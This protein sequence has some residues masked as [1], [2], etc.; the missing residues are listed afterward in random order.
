[1]STANTRRGS[2]VTITR[3]SPGLS[4]SRRSTPPY[5]AP[6]VAANA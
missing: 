6:T 3:D 1:M 4:R 2:I 5:F